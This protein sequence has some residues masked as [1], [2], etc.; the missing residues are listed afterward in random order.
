LISLLFIFDLML[1]GWI[2]L[3]SLRSDSG[4]ALTMYFLDVGQGDSE[5]ITIDGIDILI[6]GGPDAKVLESLSKVM[7]ATDRYIDLVILSHP[8][9]DHFGGLTD[10]FKNYEVGVFIDS[11]HDHTIS[12]YDYFKKGLVEENIKRINLGKGDK[13]KYKDLVLNFLSPAKIGQKELHDNTLVF[14]LEK[15]NFKTLFTGDI[16]F[17]VEK[18]LVRDYKNLAANLLKVSHHG[19][20]NS[21]SNE[22]L[23]AVRPQISVIGVGRNSYGHPKPALLSR[24][25]SSGTQ[26]YRTDQ[27]GTIKAVLENGRLIIAK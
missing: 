5:L 21:T 6:D 8:H 27:D 9:L 18:N 25:Q 1:W 12:Q 7:P 17:K 22:F 20:A 15:E 23:R 26:I 11:G 24:L 10:V 16:N 2:L 3:S 19:S 4:Q 14:M 13:I